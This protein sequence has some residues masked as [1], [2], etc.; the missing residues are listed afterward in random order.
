MQGLQFQIPPAP[1]EPLLTGIPNQISLPWYRFFA[2]LFQAVGSGTA[3]LSLGQLIANFTTQ[4]IALVVPAWLRVSGSPISGTSGLN[5]TFTVQSATI[6]ANEVLASPD[7]ANGDLSPRALVG[8]DLPNPAL[9]TKGG[10]K[11][12]NAVTHNFLTS[13]DTSGQPHEAQPA[14]TDVSG[15]LAGSQSAVGV[16]TNSNAHAGYPGEFL[17]S[18]VLI[19]SAVALMT[20]TPANVTSLSLAAGDWDVYGAVYFAPAGTTIIAGEQGGISTTTGTLPTAPAGGYAEVQG[21]TLAAGAEVSLILGYTRVS[22]A[23]TT[24]IYL[25]AEAAFT[26]STCGV[27]GSISAR[28]SANVY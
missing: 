12:I 27:Y 1:S 3:P 26:V 24:T 4:S 17:S 23:T 6:N 2:A 16:P 5:G 28:R 10:V 22:L 7:G 11:A 20:A 21:L 8:A 18:T 15:S 9:T 19:G 14:F 25:V 13:I